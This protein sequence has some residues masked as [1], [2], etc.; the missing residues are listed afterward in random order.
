MD[1]GSSAC[2]Q[3]PAFFAGAA[4]RETSEDRRKA[5]VEFFMRAIKGTGIKGMGPPIRSA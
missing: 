4:S 5:R 2:P 3:A 1:R